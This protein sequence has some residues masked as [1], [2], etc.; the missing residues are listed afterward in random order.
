LGTKI[1]IQANQKVALPFNLKFKTSGSTHSNG[2]KGKKEK[3][4][5]NT[6]GQ[7]KEARDF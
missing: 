7:H 5:R 3:E 6:P 1:V 4:K 2:K